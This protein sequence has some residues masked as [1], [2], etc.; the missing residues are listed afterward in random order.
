MAIYQVRS[1][2]TLVT[3]GKFFHCGF[4]S[5]YHK[6][7][8]VNIIEKYTRIITESISNYRYHFS[9]VVSLE[10]NII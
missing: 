5:A 9:V 2:D 3:M 1:L 8:G 6:S 10:E 4:C 7:F